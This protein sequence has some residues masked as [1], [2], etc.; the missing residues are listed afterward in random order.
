M[1]KTDQEIRALRDTVSKLEKK[2][3]QL[4]F[5][6]VQILT[7][8]NEGG[9]P[10]A[11][12]GGGVAP[13]APV[14]VDIAPLEDRLDQLSQSIASKEDLQPILNQLKEMHDERVKEAEETIDNVTV[15]LEKGLTLT[16]ITASLKQ[17]EAHLQEI[18][19]PPEK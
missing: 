6:L 10:S 3:D 4:Q 12:E 16:E 9:V 14:A 13:G 5:Y 2:V 7:K 17:I 11:E 1:P 19:T 8:I 15:L 18:V